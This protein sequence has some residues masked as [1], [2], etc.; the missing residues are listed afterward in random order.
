M[1]GLGAAALFLL[2]LGLAE[3][4]VFQP[5]TQ[6]TG[7]RARVEGVY[8]YDRARGVTGG[9]ATQFSVDDQFAAVVDWGSLPPDMTVAARWYNSLGMAVGEAGPA[10]AAQ[11]AGHREVPIKVPD[12]LNRNLPGEYEFVVER[13]AGGQPVELLARRMVLVRRTL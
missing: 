2:L 5:F 11:L 3:F 12:G 8:H 1:V 9:A 10:P 7:T 4:V 6:Q 13:F